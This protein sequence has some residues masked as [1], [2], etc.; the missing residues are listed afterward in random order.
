MLK[1]A[2]SNIFAT[3]LN[4]TVAIIIPKTVPKIKLIIFV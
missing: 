4:P 1:I 2:V 3:E